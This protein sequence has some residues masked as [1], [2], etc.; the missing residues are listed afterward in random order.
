MIRVIIHVPGSG[1]Q[2]LEGLEGQSLMQLAYFAGTAGIVAECGGNAA[3]GTCHVRVRPPWS[4]RV[5][6]PTTQELLTLGGLPNRDSAS[7]LSCCIKLTSALD[8]L[9]AEVCPAD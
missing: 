1:I 3:C 7:R 4:T 6:P 8:G 9:Q 2:T 5:P